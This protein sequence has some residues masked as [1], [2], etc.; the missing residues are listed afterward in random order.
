MQF[1]CNSFGHDVWR[2]AACSSDVVWPLPSPAELEAYYNKEAYFQGDAP[3]SYANYDLDTEAVL[4]LYRQLLGSLPGAAERS[5]LDIGCA[6]G[7]HLAIAAEQGWKAIG[8]EVSQHAREVAKQRHGHRISVHAAIEDV[9]QM[10]FDLITLFDVIEHLPQPYDV[11]RSLFQ[12]GLIGEKTTVVF[13]TPNARSSKAVADPAQWPYR[14][15]P[16][17]LFYYSAESLTRFWAALGVREVHVQ[18]IYPEERAEPSRFPDE[19]SVLN[20]PTEIYAGLLCTARGFAASAHYQLRK[21]AEQSRKLEAEAEAMRARLAGESE[22]LEAARAEIEKL[23]V[24]HAALQALRKTKW[25]RLREA[26]ASRPITLRSMYTAAYLMASMAA[27][28]R[29]RS[30]VRRVVFRSDRAP[31]E[32]ETPVDAYVV[33][34]PVVTHRSR[35]RVVHVIANFMTG[36]SSRLV[37]DLIER[38]GQDYAHSVLTSFI[39]KPPAFVNLD[40]TELRFPADETP[41]LKHLRQVKPAIVH[42]HYWGDVDEPWYAKAVAAA[43]KLGIQ[44]VEN[45]NTPVQPYESRAV[46]RYVYVSDYVRRVFGKDDKAHVTIYPGSDFS[47]FAHDPGAEPAED[48]IGMVYRLERDKLGEDAILPFIAA[49]RRR[50]ATHVLIVGGGDLLQ[51]FRK[52]VADAGVQ[53]SFE[54]TGYVPYSA[55]PDLYRR[56]SVFV[57]P[58]RK[59]SFGQ[60]S[61]FAMNMGIP[62]C[63]YDVGAI[64]EIVQDASL[65]APAADA[66][67]LAAVIVRLLDSPQERASVGQRQH[68]HAQAFFSVEAMVEAY[69]HLYRDLTTPA[70]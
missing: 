20:A 62:V 11:V 16:A 68:E 3:G 46:S 41:F 24:S 50:P 4:P 67:A 52:A 47:H 49:V 36:G 14:H 56:M 5:T 53:D 66:E 6:Y 59:E 43:E 58:V 13:T 31:V 63:G 12:R 26:L 25:F 7:T 27:P 70:H 42:V 15:P 35:P 69:R 30:L 44:V 39:P 61:A 9:P 29:L 54:F 45:V 8:V 60:V 21:L 32:V 64:A 2:C 23:Q 17:H 33:R 19:K 10:E 38:L 40:I 18:G 22:K 28:R 57:A 55:L 48:C 1:L 65:V 51:P 37:V 34:Q